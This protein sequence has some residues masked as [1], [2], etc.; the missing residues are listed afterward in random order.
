MKKVCLFVALFLLSAALFAQVSSDPTNNFYT[1]VERWESLGLIEKQASLRPYALPVVKKILDQVIESDSEI[2]SKVAREIYEDTFNKPWGLLLDATAA[3]TKTE[4]DLPAAA[5]AKYGFEGDFFA[6]NHISAGYQLD[7]LST[8]KQDNMLLPAYRVYPFTLADGAGSTIKHYMEVDGVFALNFADF[9]IQGGI[10]HNSFGNFYNDSIVFSPDARH[11]ANFTLSYNPGKW[12]YTQAMFVLGATTGN[13]LYTNYPNKWLFLHSLDWN[14]TDKIALSFYETSIFGNRFDP[15]YLVPMLYMVTQGVTGYG[16][17]NLLMGGAFSYRPLKGL[18]ITGDF[19]LDDFGLTGLKKYHTVKLHAAGQLGVKYVP[20]KYTPLQMVKLNYTM[21]TPFMYS[22]FQNINIK[23]D[24]VV[25]RCGSLDS[26]NYQ[27]YTNSGQPIG[28]SLESDS[29]RIALS[30]SYKPVNGLTFD[31]GGAFIRHGNVTETLSREEKLSYLA[32]PAGYFATDGS[33]YQSPV[34]VHNGNT[35]KSDGSYIRSAWYKTM[36][37]NQENKE[38]TIQTDANVTYDF[39]K[40]KLGQ[41]S[42]SLGYVFEYV[43]NK[44]VGTNML[45]GGVIFYNEN[46]GKYYGSPSSKET[47][48]EGQ[49]PLT[50]EELDLIIDSAVNNWKAQFYDVIN[51]YLTINFKYTF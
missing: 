30:V 33:I 35:D 41:F 39:P 3:A 28:S 24:P 7:F 46:D 25:S 47:G 43:H 6:L 10:N 5:F 20:Q 38:Y 40:C 2:E 8:I 50:D 51:H 19:Y 34:F 11:T 1:Q 37:L 23:S 16:E 44:G 48:F 29:D 27:I 49:T 9:Y 31:F 26:I 18:D 32:S 42:L 17:D 13:N 14:I 45:P 15:A 4:S 12:N 22:H 21:V 36:F